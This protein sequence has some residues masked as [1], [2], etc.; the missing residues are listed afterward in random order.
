M[1]AGRAPTPS[2][3]DYA[4]RAMLV[5]PKSVWDDAAE[6]L[7]RATMLAEKVRLAE[8]RAHP[9]LGMGTLAA[10]VADWPKCTLPEVCPLQKAEA[11]AAL[12][13]GMVRV[14]SSPPDPGPGH[15]PSAP[16]LVSGGS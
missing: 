9:A 5:L 7:V 8:G 11:L 14:F 2:D 1:I 15:G 16:R 3:V 4:V 6:H 10:T 12:S 13:R